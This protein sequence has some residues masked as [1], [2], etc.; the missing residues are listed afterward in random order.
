M[1][2]RSASKKFW[3]L[4]PHPRELAFRVKSVGSGWGHW[5]RHLEGTRD[6]LGLSMCLGQHPGRNL[7][8][9]AFF[10]PCP[11]SSASI[12]HDC[13]VFW[14][15]VPGIWPRL[16][17]LCSLGSLTLSLGHWTRVPTWILA[18]ALHRGPEH[19][20]CFA[21]LFSAP[22]VTGVKP[23]FL[24][25]PVEPY[26]LA[27]SS[28]FDLISHNSTLYLLCPAWLSYCISMFPNI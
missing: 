14:A 16:L 4:P 17:P 23:P 25:C 6:T 11:T 10:L 26:L 20:M 13:S 28:F 27:V 8:T 5:K 15:L 3:L 24:P 9:L 18:S 2:H 1:P 7:V 12:N 22:C 19:V 21:Q